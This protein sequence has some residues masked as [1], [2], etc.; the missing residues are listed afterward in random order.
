MSLRRQPASAATYIP[1]AVPTANGFGVTS[2]GALGFAEDVHT[3]HALH[4]QIQQLQQQV[5]QL[6]PFKKDEKAENVDRSVTNNREAFQKLS[7]K[8]WPR[9]SVKTAAPGDGMEE[10]DED[11]QA[12]VPAAEP[13][14]VLPHKPTE[15]PKKPY[16][17][18][19]R[20]LWSQTQNA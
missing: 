14:V 6:A 18:S 17:G 3:E 4:S 8:S 1:R 2:T 15:R 16:A 11:N 19:D 10:D 20:K 5:K 7:A 13:G 12:S 9:S